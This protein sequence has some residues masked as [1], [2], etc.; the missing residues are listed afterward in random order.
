MKGFLING[1]TFLFYCCFE[2]FGIFHSIKMIDTH[3]QLF[4]SVVC[5]LEM[6]LG[7]FLSK[8][9]IEKTQKTKQKKQ[10]HYFIP[11]LEEETN[12]FYITILEEN[13]EGKE[14]YL[15]YNI[16]PFCTR[17]PPTLSFVTSDDPSEKETRVICVLETDPGRPSEECIK[18]TVVNDWWDSL[19]ENYIIKE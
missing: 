4:K 13:A 14:L 19:S 15:N 8:R 2:L 16:G 1:L 18:F 11:Y 10:F 3:T 6:L 9:S 17:Y 12:F 7:P 5:Y